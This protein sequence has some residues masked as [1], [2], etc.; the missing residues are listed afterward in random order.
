MN[1]RWIAGFF[2]S[3]YADPANAFYNVWAIVLVILGIGFVIFV[4]ELGHFL[5]AKW[6][7]V[8]VEM[9]SLGFGPTLVSWRK[10]FGLRRGSTVRQ[11]EAHVAAAD[12][13]ATRA[14]VLEKYGETE[15]SIRALPLGGFV[16]MLG[17]DP[18]D[19]SIAARD[20]RA[21]HNKPVGARMAIITAGVVMNMIFGIICAT[22]IHMA[23]KPY[24][25]AV[26][27]LVAAGQPAYEAGLRPGDEVVAIDG[28]SDVTF[29]DI[30][31]ATQLSKAGQKIEFEVKR[32]GLPST[33]RLEIEPKRSGNAPAVAVGIAA[34]S[35]LDLAGKPPEGLGSD[36]DHYDTVTAAGA[37][38]GNP[39]PVGSMHDLDVILSRDRA[40]PLLVVAD[41]GTMENRDRAAKTRV[42]AT[43][44]PKLF[45][46]LGLRM[47][48]GPVVAIRPVS[49][50]ASAGFKVGDRIVSIDG[51]SNLD[52]MRLPDLVADRAGKVI[53][54]EV[55]RGDD[56]KAPPI[57][58]GVKPD[59][60][61]IWTERTFQS[62]P[63][64]VPGLGLAVAVE[65][66]VAAVEV[67]SPAHKAKIAVG[68]V[69]KAVRLSHTEDGETT[70]A[71]KDSAVDSVT[72]SWPGVFDAL[73]RADSPIRLV[74]S[75]QSDAV[76]LKAAP[77]SGWFDPMR[78]L[79]FPELFRVHAPE[80][81]GVAVRKGWGDALDM[82]TSIFGLLRNLISGRI[83][84]E[85]FGGPIM[86]SKIAYKIAQTRDMKSFL[87]FLGFL[88]VNLAVMNFFPIPPLDGGQMIFL[89]AEKVRG[90]PLPEN[91]VAYPMIIGIAF[92]LILFVLISLKDVLSFF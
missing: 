30:S 27:G 47:T 68:S 17:E 4:H 58:V 31:R 38:G 32:P 36:K 57:R 21:F 20:P 51:V 28:K 79:A 77:V 2:R 50:A 62:E 60:S 9:F 37:V 35:S 84:V 49:P 89:V 88:S 67:G 18:G 19:Q 13:D 72:A 23:G 22:Y 11:Y 34:A 43:V 61:P 26:I 70:W 25:P 91:A 80:T 45:V 40:K 8:K 1:F 74:L 64:E 87:G 76:E 33:I 73:Q 71:K 39:T 56:P 82:S 81:F 90:R 14:A 92:I 44:A 65:P 55:R 5:V 63:L 66:K 75:G 54:V 12:D 69:V 7:G 86:I 53:F 15:Y 85:G 83:G 52:P 78:G 16:K 29:Q 6:A 41:R 59:D 10:G 48:L 3:I 24:T 46:D 42:E